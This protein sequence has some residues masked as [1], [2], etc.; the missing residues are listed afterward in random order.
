M[1]FKLIFFSVLSILVISCSQGN[2]DNIKSEKE[3]DRLKN[4][5]VENDII[6]ELPK[7]NSNGEIIGKIGGCGYN[8]TPET[9]SIQIYKPRSRELSQINSILK[10]SGLSS[11]F[12]IYGAS[13]D[14]AIAT[15]VDN[16]RFIL[17]D[18]Q[19]LSYSDSK[20]GDY[21]SSMSIL[22]H[23]IGH[24]LSGHTLTKDGS[25]PTDEL[26]ADKYSGFILYKLG[27]SLKQSINAINNLGNVNA[28]STHPSKKQRIK[29][30]T[31]GWNEANQTRYNGAIPPPP[32]DNP[33]DFY[34]YTLND[35]ISSEYRNHPSAEIWYDEYKFLYG[36]I[37]EV[38]S[39]LSTVKVHIVKSSKEFS[40][41]FRNIKNEDWEIFLNQ[42]SWGGDND[43]SHAASMQLKYFLV[44]GRRIK[45]SMVESYPGAGTMM[46]GAWFFTYMEALKGNSF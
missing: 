1:N 34:V 20:S 22:A 12:E 33:N 42:T 6:I 13:I 44:P 30:I 4:N 43:M 24:H 26:E 7:N 32:N 21:W 19:L 18:P 27:A 40:N 39:D 23:E 14:N 15:I 11:N 25:N 9:K 36:V 37:T 2:K 3:D 10:F 45:F 41:D 29:A 31:D 38:S 17:Y 8:N 28:T 35:L 5:N 46:N 16:K